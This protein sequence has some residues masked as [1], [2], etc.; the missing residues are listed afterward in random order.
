MKS[1]DTKIGFSI[2]VFSGALPTAKWGDLKTT[3]VSVLRPVGPNSE[4]QHS[5]SM[6]VM[7]VLHMLAELRLVLA[8]CVWVVV[9]ARTWPQSLV[10]LSD[11]G[12]Y[13]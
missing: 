2:C 1:S 9:P 3:S 10:Q 8:D 13:S 5:M 11:D 6:F 7:V 12:L 4:L